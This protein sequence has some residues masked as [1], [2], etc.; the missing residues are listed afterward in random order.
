MFQIIADRSRFFWSYRNIYFSWML[1]LKIPTKWLHAYQTKTLKGGL[2]YCGVTKL[3]QRTTWLQMVPRDDVHE[4]NISWK[5]PNGVTYTDN[6]FKMLLKI[7]RMTNYLTIAWIDPTN[8]GSWSILVLYERW[9]SMAL[10]Y[11]VIG[12]EQLVLFFGL[13]NQF[14]SR[15]R[16]CGRLCN[17]FHFHDVF[18]FNFLFGIH[19]IEVRSC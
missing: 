2:R 6:F 9:K 1:I 18:F 8:T 5:D 19:Q 3:W 4:E 17:F 15:F 14:S 13:L 7:A 12:G 11:L 16:F 10:D